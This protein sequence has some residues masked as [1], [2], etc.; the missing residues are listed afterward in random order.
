MRLTTFVSRGTA[1]AVLAAMK[2]GD[3]VPFPD[4]AGIDTVSA[5][6]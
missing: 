6:D 3:A 2:A 4:L 5:I 1:I